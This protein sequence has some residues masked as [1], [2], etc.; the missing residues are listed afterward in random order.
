MSTKPATTAP[1]FIEPTVLYTFRELQSRCGLGEVALRKMRKAG[2]GT[3]KFGNSRFVLGR[4]FIEFI[5]KHG[6]D[7]TVGDGTG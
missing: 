1:G 3:R 2:L 6:I 4:S 5:E 7:E